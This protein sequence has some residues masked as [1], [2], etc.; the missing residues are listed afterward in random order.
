MPTKE[1]Q[2]WS[3]IKNQL[4]HIFW[5][6]SKESLIYN[7]IRPCY[8]ARFPLLFRRSFPRGRERAHFRT[9]A[10]NRAY[11]VTESNW[12]KCE[13]NQ[14]WLRNDY[15]EYQR[16]LFFFSI[17]RIP[18]LASAHKGSYCVT[19]DSVCVTV[20]LSCFTLIYICN[21]EVRHWIIK[22]DL[23]FL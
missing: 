19:A 12:R 10:G 13:K 9:A 14:S 2:K 1:K 17:S 21:Y 22:T 6:I 7:S 23:V 20:V 4:Q 18:W 8:Q 15:K 11:L 16:I 3:K 5:G